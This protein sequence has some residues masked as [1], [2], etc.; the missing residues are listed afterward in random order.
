MNDE[1]PCRGGCDLSFPVPGQF[2]AA[3]YPGEGTLHDPAA[4][5]NLK[6]LGAIVTFDYLHRPITDL[7]HSL[8]QFRT[9]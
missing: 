4:Q 1:E 3:S 9:P 8:T 2:T 7:F 5:Q 6:A